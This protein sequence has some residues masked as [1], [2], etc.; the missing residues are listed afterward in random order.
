M[1]TSKINE[2][3]FMMMMM[4]MELN[5]GIRGVAEIDWNGGERPQ[6]A[7]PSQ[8]PPFLVVICLSSDSP[9]NWTVLRII[10]K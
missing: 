6:V 1:T 3:M 9:I 8:L 4:M 5:L 10:L 7:M 2:D